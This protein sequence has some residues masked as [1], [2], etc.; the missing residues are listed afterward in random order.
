[1]FSCFEQ[2]YDTITFNFS[3]SKIRSWSHGSENLTDVINFFVG[4]LIGFEVIS[5][6]SKSI[7][8][9]NVSEKLTKFDNILSRIFFLIEEYMKHLVDALK[10]GDYTD[11][12][13][14]E[15]RHDNITKF[16]ALASRIVSEDT[17]YTKIDAMNYF[18]VL[19]YMDKITDFIRYSY[20][21]TV[22]FEKKV[23]KS[24]I[25]LAEETLRSFEM[26][27]HFFYKF[28]YKLITEIDELRGQIKKLY[29]E[30]S[31]KSKESSITSNF[32]SI[33]EMINGILKP[34]VALE[35]CKKVTDDK[36][37]LN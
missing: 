6:T 26:Y 14:G 5:Q 37:T 28:D 32:D 30:N 8:I 18:T 3:K 31:K 21:N 27:R 13:E 33:V 25:K 34:R 16:V 2:G 4:R 11:L 20:R 22:S 17:T 24:T 23:T 12:K 35:L 9:G 29:L 1:M 19:H 7:T 10:T 15:N 36:L